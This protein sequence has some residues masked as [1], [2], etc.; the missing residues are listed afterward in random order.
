MDKIDMLKLQSCQAEALAIM[1]EFRKALNKH[2][3]VVNAN[4]VRLIN[5]RWDKSE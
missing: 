2:F 3:E 1:H 4:A 5:E